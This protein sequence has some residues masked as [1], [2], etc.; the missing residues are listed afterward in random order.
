MGARAEVSQKVSLYPYA[1]FGNVEHIN[2]LLSMLKTDFQ[3][4]VANKRIVDIG[5]GDGD[6]SF[7]CELLGA[8]EVTAID[9]ADTNFNFMQGVR[10]LRDCMGSKV[11]ICSGNLEDMDLSFLGIRDLIFFLGASRA[12]Q[13]PSRRKALLDSRVAA[14][15]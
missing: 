1:S 8:R 10:A 6:V 5:C 3:Q 7:I 2:R 14:N 4:L 9:W 12:C 11:Q 13:S 15:R